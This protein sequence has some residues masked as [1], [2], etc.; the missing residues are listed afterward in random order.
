MRTATDPGQARGGLWAAVGRDEVDLDRLVDELLRLDTSV[1]GLFRTTREPQRLDGVDIPAGAILWPSF[2]AASRDLARFPDPDRLDLDR[3]ADQRHLTFGHGIH[4]CMGALLARIQVREVISA[5][6]RRFPALRLPD[7]VGLTET[8]RLAT[9]GV[10]H[11]PV[12][13]R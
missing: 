6:A 2:A 7:G 3:L 1:V 4:H 13:C 9:R 12:V 10:E 8:P 11:L 5:L